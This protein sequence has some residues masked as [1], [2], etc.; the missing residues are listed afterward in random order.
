MLYKTKTCPDCNISRPCGPICFGYEDIN[1][2]HIH[3][4]YY[5]DK[6]SIVSN[7]IYCIK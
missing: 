3:T 4:N 1:Y 7:S 6:L 5:K 2:Q